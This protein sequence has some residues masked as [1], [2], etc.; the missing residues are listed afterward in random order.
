MSLSVHF[1]GSCMLPFPH[2]LVQVEFHW[3]VCNGLDI[4]SA[5]YDCNVISCGVGQLYIEPWW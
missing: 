1:G 5:K 3:C 4:V 2:L